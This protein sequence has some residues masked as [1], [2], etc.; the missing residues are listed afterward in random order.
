MKDDATLNFIWTIMCELYNIIIM[1][2]I[3]LQLLLHFLQ[4]NLQKPTK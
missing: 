4:F 2:F 3:D 1:G